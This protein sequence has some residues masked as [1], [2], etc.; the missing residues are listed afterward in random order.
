M[1]NGASKLVVYKLVF[2]FTV[3]SAQSL[4]PFDCVCGL[5]IEMLWV[6]GGRYRYWSCVL[7]GASKLVMYKV[8]VQSLPPCERVVRYLP[9]NGR[10]GWRAG[11]RYRCWSC[12]LNGAGKLV[13][14]FAVVQS[15]PP[16]ER[17]VRY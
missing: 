9:A 16:C 17:V 7:N 12:A 13:F 4:P 5:P 2:G 15:L 1:L 10:C 8:V 3:V 6:A 14:G 11:V